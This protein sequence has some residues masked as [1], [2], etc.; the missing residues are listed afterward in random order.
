VKKLL[1]FTRST[2]VAVTLIVVVLLSG[3][4]YAANT[5][6]SSDIVDGQVKSRDIGKKAVRTPDIR[7][8]A[9]TS[10]KVR[11]GS[12]RVTDFRAADRALLTGPAGATGATGATGPAGPFLDTLPSGKSEK[13]AYIMRGTAAAAGGRA[14]ADISFAIPL[15]TAPTAHFLD[16]GAAATAV[17]P[18]TAA[19]PTAAPGHLCIY[20][21]ANNN[22]SSVAFQDPVTTATGTIV[23]P[24]GAVVI[25]AAGAAGAFISSGGWAVTAP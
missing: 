4:A 3:T 11:D 8:G 13:G 5:I 9:V 17:C 23:R 6:R 21:G 19:A 16:E 14:G 12:L 25:G 24:Y 7:G 18:G 20:E 15:A 1:R 2:G 22:L 10:G